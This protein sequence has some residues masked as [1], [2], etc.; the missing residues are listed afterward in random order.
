MRREYLEPAMVAAL[1]S[2]EALRPLPEYQKTIWLLT[3]TF[4]N[5]PSL[6]F[7]TI[8]NWISPNDEG[9]SGWFRPYNHNGALTNCM[10]DEG[11]ALCLL[12]LLHHGT[13][14]PGSCPLLHAWCA[15]ESRDPGGCTG[16]V[17]LC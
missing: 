6:L 8:Y 1:G 14:W 7:L 13:Y 10:Y 17:H 12:V 9:K 3:S 15:I 4:R 11:D 2:P 5:L 16:L